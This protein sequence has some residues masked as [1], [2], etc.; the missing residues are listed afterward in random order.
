MEK[1]NRGE[2]V[3]AL[4]SFA[5]LGGVASLAQAQSESNSSK[6]NSG[7]PKKDRVLD[8]SQTFQYDQLP[9]INLPNGGTQRKVISGVLPTCEYI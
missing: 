4:S 1:M 5:A 9:V 6:M 8:Q 7:H 3:I 2:L